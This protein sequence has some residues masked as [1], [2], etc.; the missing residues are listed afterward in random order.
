MTGNQGKYG[1]FF[2][3][4][5][6]AS[7]PE[8][9]YSSPNKKLGSTRK[10]FSLGDSKSKPRFQHNLLIPTKNPREFKKLLTGSK[11]KF[12]EM[13]K[14][15]HRLDTIKFKPARNTL[16]VK[17]MAEE[18]LSKGTRYKSMEEKPK[19][20][21]QPPR[22]K[23]ENNLYLK[24]RTP[25]YSPTKTNNPNKSA[26]KTPMSPT[27]TVKINDNAITNL[28]NI[29]KTPQ[30]H[31]PVQ[32]PAQNSI[33]AAYRTSNLPKINKSLS[34]SQ[35]QPKNPQ[36]DLQNLSNPISSPPTKSSFPVTTNVKFLYNFYSITTP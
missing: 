5:S 26:F 18:I 34:F 35:T 8:L 31:F 2:S 3:E 24:T 10:R 20:K 9:D 32:N 27:K 15:K 13:M 36:N 14:N 6:H 28:K 1:E 17:P 21:S 25:S 22:R 33:K 12:M 11:H 19:M 23:R 29:P 7:T 4:G 16:H 30:R